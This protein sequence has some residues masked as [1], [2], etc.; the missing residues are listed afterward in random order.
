M[1]FYLIIILF[2]YLFVHLFNYSFIVYSY[3]LFIV[4]YD[5]CLYDDLLLMLMYLL[6]IL[7]LIHD[8]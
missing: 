3:Y 8:C 7:N 4:Q 6:I 5:A 2:I 1:C